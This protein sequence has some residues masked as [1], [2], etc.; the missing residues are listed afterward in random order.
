[1]PRMN[2]ATCA[3]AMLGLFGCK[4]DEPKKPEQEHLGP[5][6]ACDP[7]AVPIEESTTTSTDEMPPP[8]CSPGLACDPLAD[9]SGYVC[10]TAFSIHGRVS[11]SLSGDAIDGALIAALDDTGAPVTDVVAS[12]SCGDYEL[13]I[14]I[15]RNAD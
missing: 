4:H 5:G 6:E 10:G 7:E 1:M 15:R 8:V 11:D 14:A 9:G 3:I 2:A 13:P 12:D